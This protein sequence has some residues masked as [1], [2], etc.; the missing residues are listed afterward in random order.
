MLT[1]LTLVPGSSAAGG[2]RGFC[3]RGY[4]ADLHD[5]SLTVTMFL[6][7]GKLCLQ[8]TG[9]W[10]ITSRPASGLLQAHTVEEAMATH[11]ESPL[12]VVR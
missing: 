10:Q 8:L 9:E 5:G 7:D 11:S 4:D 3:V 2:P 12:L 1:M 6:H